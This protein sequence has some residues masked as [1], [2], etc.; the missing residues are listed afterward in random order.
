MKDGEQPR[1]EPY[2]KVALDSSAVSVR[3]ALAETRK[4][5]HAL[6]LE[7]EVAWT[8]EQVLAEMMNNV[9]EH[10][11]RARGDGRI[12]LT[13]WA[14]RD[15]LTFQMRDD[16]HPMPD[17]RLPSGL[18]ASLDCAFEDLPEGGFGWHLIH[19]LAADLSY[20][21]E[22]ATNVLRFRMRRDAIPARP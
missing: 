21:R 7:A 20:V 6:H 18:P 14:D 16:G 15:E 8:V 11:Y 3:S 12:E 2:L 9:C 1:S 22:G 17:G 19:E 4:G 13:V 5:L 10:A